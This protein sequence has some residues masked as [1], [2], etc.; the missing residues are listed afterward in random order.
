VRVARLTVGIEYNLY[1]AACTVL[2]VFP[3]RRR[4]N[5]YRVLLR[6]GGPVVRHADSLGNRSACDRRACARVAGKK[7]A[8]R[9]VSSAWNRPFG[10][11]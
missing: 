5:V 3:K 6:V 2:D 8:Q 11:I 10:V 1:P 7:S 9:I 4:K